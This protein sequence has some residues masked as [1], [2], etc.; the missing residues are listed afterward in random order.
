[1]MMKTKT[2]T[3]LGAACS[4]ACVAAAPA[5]AADMGAPVYKAP[6]AAVFNW[7][8][9]Y[10]GGTIGGGM[11]SL[12]VTDMDDFDTALNGPTLKSTGVV[13]GLHAGYNWQV[14]PSFL[15]GIEGDFNW[16]SFKDSDTTCFGNCSVISRFDPVVATSKLDNFS[17]L[18]A[19]FGLV[20]DRT[21]LYVTA[22]PAWG[23]VDASLTDFNCPAC[24][25]PGQV[26]A[27]AS[28]SSYRIGIAAG[29]GVEYALT[30][31]WILRGEYLHLDFSN[32]DAQFI[33]PT[34]LQPNT[35]FRA[36]SSATADLAR[37]GVSYKI[38]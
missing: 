33:E 31:N 12:P 32:K 28:D 27:A 30:Q 8:G 19:R 3:L 10:V 15:V 25:P 24:R 9:F 4:V 29:A 22:G 20:A 36:R 17:T 26:F 11:A 35:S 23:H 21:L 13:G 1:M 37:I 16:S 7:T 34:A 2:R 38:W 18:R 6:A 14:A 5:M